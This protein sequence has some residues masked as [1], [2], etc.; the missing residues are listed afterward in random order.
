MDTEVLKVL[1]TWL[2]DIENSCQHMD[3]SGEV[4]LKV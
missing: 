1:M 3:W 4:T 2:P